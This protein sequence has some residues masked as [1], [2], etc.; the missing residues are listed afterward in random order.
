MCQPYTASPH[1]V[2]RLGGDV[3]EGGQKTEFYHSRAALCT[4]SGGTIYQNIYK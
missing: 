2:E 4:Q 1:P 3:G